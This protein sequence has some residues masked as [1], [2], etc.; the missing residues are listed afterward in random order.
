[1]LGDNGEVMRINTRLIGR[2]LRFNEDFSVGSFVRFESGSEG[3]IVSVYL[4]ENDVVMQV[5][6]QGALALVKTSEVNGKRIELL[7]PLGDEQTLRSMSEVFEYFGARYKPDDS[8]A[9]NNMR[10]SKAIED[11]TG[12][13]ITVHIVP[14]MVEV[15]ATIDELGQEIGPYQIPL[16]CTAEKVDALIDEV[17]DLVDDVWESNNAEPEE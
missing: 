7:P 3:I 2:R 8:L 4:F 17:S 15:S 6:S 14:P 9:D 10:L 13:G 11:D 1:M 5:A 12:N 16:P